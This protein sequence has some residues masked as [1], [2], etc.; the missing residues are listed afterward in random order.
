[1]FVIMVWTTHCNMHKRAV[2]RLYSSFAFVLS[3]NKYTQAASEDMQQGHRDSSLL[4][5]QETNDYMN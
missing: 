2:G 4:V 5:Q 3:V 1:M